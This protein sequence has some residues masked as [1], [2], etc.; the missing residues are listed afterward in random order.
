VVTL[1][2]WVTSIIVAPNVPG[3]NVSSSVELGDKLFLQRFEMGRTVLWMRKQETVKLDQVS[4]TEGR[5]GRTWWSSRSIHAYQLWK[6]D[7]HRQCSNKRNNGIAIG[8]K[9]VGLWVFLDESRIGK[10]MAMMLSISITTWYGL[11][12]IFTQTRTGISDSVEPYERCSIQRKGMVLMMKFRAT[13]Q[14][15]LLHAAC[16]ELQPS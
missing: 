2:D 14:L 13:N 1:F 10:F 6:I 4:V 7:F 8:S 9:W 3:I 15:D 16:G 12:S 11:K 5:W